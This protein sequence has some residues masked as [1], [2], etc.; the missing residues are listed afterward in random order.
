MSVSVLGKHGPRD[1]EKWESDS[2]VIRGHMPRQTREL[3][4][5]SLWC[6]RC[7][8]VG[9]IMVCTYQEPCNRIPPIGAGTEGGLMD[10]WMEARDDAHEPVVA[11]ARTEAH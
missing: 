5:E 3:G 8:I 10:A 7:G 9:S 11:L 4:G 1:T 6:E 2:M